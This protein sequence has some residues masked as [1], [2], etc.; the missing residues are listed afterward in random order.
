MKP[1]AIMA[2]LVDVR[3]V[4]AHKSV[5]LEIHVPSEQAGEVLKAFGWP[6]M[7]DPVQVAIARIHPEK[8]VSAPP[9]PAND[10][11]KQW[12]LAQQAG[13]L[14]KKPS[15]A[16]FLKET[17]G[18]VVSNPDGAAEYV[19]LYCRVSSRSELI[20]NTEAGNRWLMLQSA[21]DA[22]VAEPAHV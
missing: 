1:A 12:S 4:A 17:L 8:S 16:K 6:T 2:N 20:S 18:L 13:Y 9:T 11:P 15:F 7:V 14:C 3:N 10:D 5:R 21:Y 22:W 19:R